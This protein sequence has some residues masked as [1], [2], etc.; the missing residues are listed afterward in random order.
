ME[1]LL[2]RVLE[3]SKPLGESSQMKKWRMSMHFNWNKRVLASSFAVL[4]MATSLYAIPK[5]PCDRTEEVCCENPKPGPFAF[6]YPMDLGLSCPRDFFVHVD[7]LA[8]QA[9]QDGMQ[10]AIEDSSSIGGAPS[11]PINYGKVHGFSSDNSDW[12]YQPGMRFGVGFFIDH[13]AWAVDFN[14]TWLNITEYKRAN[15][16]TPGGVLIP[17]WI[18]GNDTP[19]ATPNCFGPQANAVWRSG[20]NTLDFSLGKP[21]HISR[22]VIVNPYFGFR[23]G[24]INQHFS[25]SYGGLQSGPNRTI[26]HGQNDFWG[27]GARAGFSSDWIVGK[28][29]C[30]FT[31]FSASML[32][33]KFEIHQDMITPVTPNGFNLDADF[34]HNVPN[35]ELA[36]GIAWSK[37]FDKNK[38][39]VGLRGAYE[40]IQWWNQLNMRKFY[41]GGPGF[42]NETV[43]RGDLSLNGFSLRL[44]IDI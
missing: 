10:F 43:A 29:V 9:K 8:F 11:A 44:Q 42:A 37:Y 39:R 41:S 4:S 31:N 25:V 35:T 13:D 38:Y 24:W 27:I 34:Y 1:A 6:S 18:L 14:W 36:I 22:Y 21:Y 2:K 3:E 5:G 23:A 32:A 15:A 16:S 12:G 33:S 30:L 28:G 17:L 20:Y 19:S 26:H 40:F 7:G